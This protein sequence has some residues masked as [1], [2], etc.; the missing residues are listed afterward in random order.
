MPAQY[1]KP[2]VSA[3]RT[4]RRMRGDLRGGSRADHALRWRDE[5]MAAILRGFGFRSNEYGFN[6]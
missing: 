4:R 1:V 3:A 2:Y 5:Q 6:C